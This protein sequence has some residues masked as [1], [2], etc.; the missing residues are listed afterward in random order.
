MFLFT[1]II[2]SFVQSISACFRKFVSAKGRASRSE[3]WW[4]QLFLY[5]LSFITVFVDGFL[6]N[7]IVMEDNIFPINM[8]TS[9]ITLFPAI[10]VLIRRL[11]DVNRSGWWILIAFTCI[12][13]IP[14]LYWSI[15]KGTDGSNDYGDDPVKI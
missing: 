5:L 8:I 1:L 10:M 4:F 13:I 14:L 7:D 2:M 3:Y 12:G 6:F 11:H 15:I 9:L